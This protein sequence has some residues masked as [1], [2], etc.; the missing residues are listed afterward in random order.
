[1]IASFLLLPKQSASPGTGIKLMPELVLELGLAFEPM[2]IIG[3]KRT[4]H[5]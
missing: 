1:M 5:R 2:R 4:P 3:I